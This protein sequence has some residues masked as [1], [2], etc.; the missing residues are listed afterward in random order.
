M[1]IE[2][3]KLVFR[4]YSYAFL[5]LSISVLVFLFAVWFSNLELITEVL[6]S[7]SIPLL[8]KISI[9]LSLLGSIATNFTAFSGAYTIIIALLFGIYVAMLTYFL[10]KRIRE[11]SGTGVATGFFGIASGV[12]GIGCA[13]CGSFLLTS[14]LA[15]VGAAG[16]I[17]LLPFDGKE[18]AVLGIILLLVSL[19]I[20]AKQITD[21]LVC[22]I[23]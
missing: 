8:Y 4:N 5:S 19:R 15:A 9:P 7:P 23:S 2:A 6:T 16:A 17:T 1:V 10:R 22:K 13:A 11:T 3:L 18:F 20:T 12:L 14:V 21:P